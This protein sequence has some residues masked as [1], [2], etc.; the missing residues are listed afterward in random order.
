MGAFAFALILSLQQ[1]S[2]AAAT[3]GRGETLFKE[4]CAQCHLNKVPRAPDIE[5][6]HMMMP[7]HIYRT[8]TEGR[9]AATG[10]TPE[11]CRETPD[12]RMAFGAKIW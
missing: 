3:S 4:N 9:D 5:Y 11:G 10:V 7:Q 12:R 8:L 2:A 6:L 1:A